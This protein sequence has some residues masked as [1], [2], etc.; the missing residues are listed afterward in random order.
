MSNAPKK[1][2]VGSMIAA[3]LVAVMAILDL[4]IKVP[5]A[6]QMKMDVAFLIGAGLVGYMGWESYKEMT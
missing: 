5:F 6:G 1:M 3:S 4:A 2:V